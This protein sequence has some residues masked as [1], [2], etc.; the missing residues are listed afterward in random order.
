MDSD[1]DSDIQQKIKDLITSNI[2]QLEC[3]RAKV[4]KNEFSDEQL[5]S[6][7]DVCY[8]NFEALDKFLQK[9]TKSSRSKKDGSNHKKKKTDRDDNDNDTT[10]GKKQSS[11]P[12]QKRKSSR[13]SGATGSNSG[14]TKKKMSK[15]L[16]DQD[17]FLQ[18][19]DD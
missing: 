14:A 8:K 5:T 9:D 2:D 4:D 3:L 1:S 12:K 17:Q 10:P 7:Y 16:D 13:S 11:T 15:Y 18:E 6:A 19:N